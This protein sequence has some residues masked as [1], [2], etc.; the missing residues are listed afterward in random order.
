MCGVLLSSGIINL[1]WNLA[2]FRSLIFTEHLSLV[3]N[4]DENSTISNQAED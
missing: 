2:S 3:L 4:K 1:L